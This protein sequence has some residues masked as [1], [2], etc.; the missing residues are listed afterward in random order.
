VREHGQVAE[1]LQ[2]DAL[3]ERGAQDLEALGGIARL[4]RRGG[5]MAALD[6]PGG[7]W[8]GYGTTG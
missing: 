2:V 6:Q 1:G 5:A 7:R 8:I 3:R 4:E